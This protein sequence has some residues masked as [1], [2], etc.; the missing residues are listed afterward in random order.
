MKYIHSP[1][2]TLFLKPILEA[3]LKANDTI[4]NYIGER[5][6]HCVSTHSLSLLRYIQWQAEP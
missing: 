4:I 5:L 1:N 2:L 6:F 3:I